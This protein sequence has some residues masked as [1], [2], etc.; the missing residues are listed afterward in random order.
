MEHSSTNCSTD[1]AL[2]HFFKSS[3]RQCCFVILAFSAA[4]CVTP[5]IAADSNNPPN[6][7]AS[8]QKDRAMCNS[9]QSNQDRATCL[10]EAGAAYGEAR[11]GQ[12]NDGQA[13]YEQNALARCNALPPEDMQA[14][15]RRIM[16]EGT[17]EGNA[18]D[19]GIY[20]RIE[21]PVVTPRN[22]PN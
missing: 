22:H 9:G 14:C 19:G 7:R 21:T 2:V 18:Q 3:F 12:L 6:A 17:T 16:G 5:T 15:Q 20:R 13:Q 10:Q 8:Y 1:L 4:L 11:R